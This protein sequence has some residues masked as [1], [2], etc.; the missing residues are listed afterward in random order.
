MHNKNAGEKL[1]RF[2]ARDEPSHEDVN[3]HLKIAGL[4]ARE[5]E[6]IIAKPV[7]I[8]EIFPDPLQPRRAIPSSVRRTHDYVN[9]PKDV[10][11]VLVSWQAKAQTEG[12]VKINVNK[13]IA[14]DEEIELKEDAPAVLVNFVK[15]MKLAGSIHETGLLQP[16]KISE[17]D[18]GG[19]VVVLGER[20]L[21]AHHMLRM[22]YGAKYERIPAIVDN[23]DIWAQAAEN[24][25]RQELNAIQT[26]RQVCRL[27]MDFYWKPGEFEDFGAMVFAGES[28]RRYWNQV[29]NGNVYR[30]NEDQ[31]AKIYGHTDLNSKNQ[32][33]QY[34]RIVR[35]LTDEEWVRADDEGWSENFIREFIQGKNA[36][37]TL[38]TV[39]LDE[40]EETLT[41]VKV[42]PPT[43]PTIPP[44]RPMSQWDDD[45]D[46]RSTGAYTPPAR[47][48]HELSGVRKVAPQQSP[49]VDRERA[50]Y[51]GSDAPPV[52]DDA[53]FLVTDIEI[54]AVVGLA[55]DIAKNREEMNA[56]EIISWLLRLDTDNFSHYD[57]DVDALND[58]LLVAVDL[59]KNVIEDVLDRLENWQV[60]R[61]TSEFEDAHGLR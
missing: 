3:S 15:L 27:I 21:L 16:I 52:L 38:T 9:N 58:E 23:Y 57:G 45:E 33:S 55:A 39:N 4:E 2:G 29:S 43:R 12:G 14:G 31:R 24:G 36:E 50:T 35:D 7:R 18:E 41:T 1:N 13:V 49:Q 48:F 56:W 22:V 60:E 37:E 53:V 10:M 32:I 59:V 44:A 19:Y 42:D 20:R 8:E 6:R 28:D 40:D 46:Y 30:L 17:R 26:A 61:I 34:R 25:V 54:E 11:K 51:I 5:G 47:D